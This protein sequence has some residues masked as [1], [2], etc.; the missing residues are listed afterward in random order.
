MSI[1]GFGAMSGGPLGGKH[2]SN[3]AYPVNCRWNP[4]CLKRHLVR[5]HKLFSKFSCLNITCLDF[6]E[7]LSSPDDPFAYLDPPYIAKGP[8]LYKYSMSD[9]DHRR[10]SQVVRG[11][12]Y[13]WV[14]SYDD[15][16]MTRDLYSWASF[17]ELTVTYTNATHANGNRP[18]NKEVVICP[19]PAAVPATG[20]LA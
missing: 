14:L 13:P 11:L 1:S 15:H 17:S 18:K 10:L 12:N 2:Q 7:V 20:G 5:C 9:D 19:P 3:A 6:Q 4:E 16:P 8:Q